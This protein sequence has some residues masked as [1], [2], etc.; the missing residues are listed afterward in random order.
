MREIPLDIVVGALDVVEIT[1]T[2]RTEKQSR[3][4]KEARK[5]QRAEV[6]VEAKRG[7]ISKRQHSSTGSSTVTWPG[8]EAKPSTCAYFS[9]SI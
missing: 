1:K 7:Q 2:E 6:R 3:A 8:G 5:R 9:D 4:G